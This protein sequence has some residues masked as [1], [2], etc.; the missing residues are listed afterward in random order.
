[1]GYSF[2]FACLHKVSKVHQQGSFLGRN[3]DPLILMKELKAAQLILQ[4]Y[5]QEV[6]VI[7]SATSHGSL[8]L[9]TQRIV[10]AQE[11]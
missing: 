3:I 8:R 1:M 10:M 4:E 7:V 6:T 2:S 9:G 5:G 11:D